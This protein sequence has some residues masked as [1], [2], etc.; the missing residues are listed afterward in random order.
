[1]PLLFSKCSIVPFGYFYPFFLSVLISYFGDLL[2]PYC[3]NEKH[4]LKDQMLV[5]DTLTLLWEPF[6]V[7]GK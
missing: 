2:W 7:Q 5:S 6:T 4:I 1:M 3:I